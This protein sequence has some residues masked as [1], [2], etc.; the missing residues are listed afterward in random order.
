MKM[1]TIAT[2]VG[3]LFC[4][5]LS[6]QNIEFKASNFKEDKDGFKNAKEAMDKGDEYFEV[7]NTAIFNVQS[8]GI[9]YDLALQQYEKAQAF[10]PNNA[11]LNYK[12]GVCYANG[13]NREKCISYLYKAYEL[14]P[15]CDPFLN[16]YYGYALQLDEKFSEAIDAY[17]AFND[18]YKKADEF[19]KFVVKRKKECKLAKAAKA[20]PE[21]VWVDN[22]SELNTKNNDYAPAVSTD[23]AEM[24]FT[25]N[26]PNDHQPNEV[27][28]YDDDLYSASKVDG[29]WTSIQ[30]LKGG[31]NTEVDEVAN[32]LSYDGTRMLLHRVDEG[33]TDIYES[34]LTG[35][36][37]SSP[38]KMPRQISTPNNNEVFAA[39]SHDGWGIYFNRSFESQ[40]NGFEVMN[41][42][43]QS[44]ISKDYKSASRITGVNSKF[45]E[46]PIYITIDGD[47]MYIASQGGDGYGGY[48]IFIS[49]RAN[50]SWGEPKNLGYPINTPYDDFYF[51]ASANGKFAYIC[52]NRAGG[53]GGYDIYKVTYWGPQKN[54][55]METED[56]LL[57]SIVNPIKDNALEATVEVKQKSFTVFKGKTIDAITKKPVQADIEIIDNSNGQV[58]ETFTTN[59]ATGKFL[60]TLAS[61][62]NY[63]IAVKA[64]GYLFHSE[65]FDIPKGSADN[66]V[67]KIIELKNIAVGS[68]IALR[69]IFFDT[70]KSVL[71]PESNAELDRLVK[72]LKDVPSLEIEISGHTDNTGSASLN[73]KLSQSRA[74]AV[75]TYLKGKGIAANRLTSQGYGSRQPIA[76]NN[77]S[78]GR[79][80]NRRTEFEIKKN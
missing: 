43:M 53:K 1:N 34:V 47:R 80:Q 71:R 38:T 69:N 31:I 66:L 54:P 55:A 51:S 30:P 57:A 9:N 78:E 2:I 17:E 15:E 44:K 52:S 3:T 39:Y 65:N 75:V 73:E 48:D 77:T 61:G 68:K 56:Y 76:T 16:F 6:A 70:G 13:A 49:E 64:E 11:T 40:G 67:N 41:S 45:N 79:Q 60:I 14:D 42:S 23:G 18:S 7:A 5:A 29:K 58:I 63:G 32:N 24:I 74:D 62:K 35:L 37:W 19:G 8:P 12:I 21:R 28:D 4:F 72:L 33:Q 46:G 50:G 20:T 26:R 10:N 25:S 36:T 22:V 27:G 59:S